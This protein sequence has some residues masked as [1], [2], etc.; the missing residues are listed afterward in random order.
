MKTTPEQRAELAR[1][2]D[3]FAS[4]YNITVEARRS[5]VFCEAIPALLAELEE[6]DEAGEI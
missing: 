5:E 6:A 4:G 1:L 2:A 3:R